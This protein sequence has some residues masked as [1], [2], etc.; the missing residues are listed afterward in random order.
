[1]M[2]ASRFHAEVDAL[3]RSL[4]PNMFKF[5]DMDSDKPY[6]KMVAITNSKNMY[7]MR[8]DLDEFPEAIPKVFITKML[9]S[10][11]GDDLDSPSHE[12]HTLMSEH[13]YTR[14]CHYGNDSWQPNVSL[15]KVYLKCRVWL[16]AY[17]AHLQT[18]DNLCDY[19]ATQY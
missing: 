8:V 5:F 17:E 18:G 1:M 6:V 14:I 10:K 7:T 15:N 2:T 11:F 16:E 19:L 3:Q 12:M 9:K 4:P 13:G